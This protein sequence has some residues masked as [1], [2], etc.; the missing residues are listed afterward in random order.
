MAKHNLAH[1]TQW[2]NIFAHQIRDKLNNLDLV[3]IKEMA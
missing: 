2:F 3:R 1:V